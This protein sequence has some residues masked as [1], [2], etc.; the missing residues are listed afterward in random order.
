[1]PPRESDVEEEGK[2]LAAYADKDKDDDGMA[3]EARAGSD[4]DKKGEFSVTS[5]EL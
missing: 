5:R 1:L 4:S 3:E 2:E